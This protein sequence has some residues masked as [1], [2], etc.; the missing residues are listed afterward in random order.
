M[1]RFSLPL[2]VRYDEEE[3]FP[4][5]GRKPVGHD[6]GNLDEG[7]VDKVVDSYVQHQTKHDQEQVLEENRDN[8]TR[9]LKENQNKYWRNTVITRHVI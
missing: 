1:S 8:Q 3:A 4:G 2:T 6:E 5:F 9:D 7:H